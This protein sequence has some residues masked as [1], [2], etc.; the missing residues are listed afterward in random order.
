MTAHCRIIIYT[1]KDVLAV[2]IDAV[3]SEDGNWFVYLKNGSKRNI[4]TAA[5]NSDFIIVEQ[6]LND[7]DIILLPGMPDAGQLSSQ[8][9]NGAMNTDN[10]SDSPPPA[11]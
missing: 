7:G 1:Q 6:G 10:S 4:K 2:P 8:K 5:S 11:F 3:N 9:N